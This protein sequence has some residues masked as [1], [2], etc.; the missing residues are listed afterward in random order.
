MLLQVE[1][2][3]PT[4]STHISPSIGIIL[5]L[6]IRKAN[7]VVVGDHL[8]PVLPNAME[9]HSSA[10]STITYNIPHIPALSFYWK[11][12][13]SLSYSSVISVLQKH[14]G[15]DKNAYIFWLRQ[16][17]PVTDLEED[18]VWLSPNH[19]TLELLQ[20][21]ACFQEAFILNKLSLCSPAI[22]LQALH[23]FL[24][25]PL[26]IQAQNNGVSSSSR[27]VVAG[28]FSP[29]CQNCHS[30]S[31]ETVHLHI[32]TYWT[33]LR[34]LA[35]RSYC[36]RSGVVWGKW[37]YICKADHRNQIFVCW[38]HNIFAIS[39]ES[40]NQHEW[41]V[42]RWKCLQRSHLHSANILHFFTVH[43]GKGIWGLWFI[44]FKIVFHS[45]SN[46]DELDLEVM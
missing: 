3:W 27:S 12:N 39:P 31:Q 16:S 43:G 18:F 6:E 46:S 10:M 28:F 13:Y 9:E 17:S 35:C 14:T 21:P 2:K 26:L 30:S 19:W 22:W 32:L 1:Q 5:E 11:L 38:R 36:R 37:K 4:L 42:S 8:A 45:R 29:G 40:F 24:L 41:N 7:S 23:H 33:W 44:S 34:Y 15:I 20:F 25:N